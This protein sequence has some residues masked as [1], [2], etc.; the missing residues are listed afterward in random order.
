MRIV[1]F[2]LVLTSL[3]APA[4]PG[5]HAQVQSDSTYAVQSDDTLYSIAQRFGVSVRALKVWN[6]LDDATLHEGQVL[7]IRPPTETPAL[8]DSTV[9]EEDRPVDTTAEAQEDTSEAVVST[10]PRPYGRHAVEAGDSFVNLAV[11]LGTTADTLFSLNDQITGALLP[12]QVLR[13][14]RR[15]GPPTHVVQSGETLYSIAGQYGVSVRALR[16]RNDLDTTQIA[17]GQRLQLPTRTAP[18]VPAHGEQAPPDSLGT[19]S[20]YPGPFAGRLTASGIPYDPDEFVVSHPSLPYQSV[21]LLS[22]PETNQHTFARVVDRGP[23][24]QGVLLDVSEVVAEQLGVARGD[25]STVAVRTVWI[26]R[27]DE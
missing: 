10:P 18:T 16:V 7:R 2:A 25:A 19:V 13:L 24:Q 15:F 6:G 21:V 14:P 5:V 11:R 8:A 27:L 3:L 9:V 4:G 17:P 22:R 23:L 26:N 12:G 1:V 20:V